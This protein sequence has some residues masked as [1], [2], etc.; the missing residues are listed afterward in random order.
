MLLLAVFAVMLGMNFYESTWMTAWAEEP[1]GISGAADGSNV[2]PD[3]PENGSGPPILSEASVRIGVL[4]GSGTEICRQMWQPTMDYLAQAISDR[5]FILVPLKFDEIEPAVRNRSV[6][7]LICNPAIYINLEVRYGMTRILSLHNRLGTRIVSE[8]GGVIFCRA[9]RTDLQNLRDVRGQRIAATDQTSFGGWVMALRE[10]RAEGMD[11]GH[12]CRQ[13]VFLDTH[14]AVV[15]AVLTDQADIGIVRTDTIERMAAGGEIRMDEIRVISARAASEGN[16]SFPYL[17]ST[18]LYPEWPI[19]K[20]SGVNDELAR[21]LTVALLVMPDSSP[22]AVAAHIGGWSVCRSYA[23]VHDCLREL[24]MPPYEHYGEI[25]LMDVWR[26]YRM[27]IMAIVV[28]ITALSGALMLLRGKQLAIM[29]VSSQNQLLL[30]SAGGGICGTDIHGMTTFVNPAAG[31]ILGYSADE[32]IGRSL[33]ALTH[34]TKPDGSPYPVHECPI[35]MAFKD[36]TVHEGSSEFFYRKD[37]SP[38]PISYSSRP[39]IDKGKITGAIVCFQDITGLKRAEESLLQINET[40]EQRVEQEVQKNMEQER[41]LIHQS[42]MAAMGEMIN[43]IAHQW[44]QPLQAINLLV[45]NIR[46]EFQWGSLNSDYLEQAVADSNRMVQKMSATISGF[47]TF[48]HSDK[49]VRR[50]FSAREQ[51]RKTVALVEESFRNSHI[52]VHID[53]PVDLMLLGFPYE[54]S[55]VLFHLLSNAGDAIQSHDKSYRGRVDVVLAEE[56]GRGCVTV[57]DTGG[58]IPEDIRGR[59]FDPYFSTKGMGNGIGLYM[60]KMIIERHMNGSITVQ[61]IEGGAEFRVSIPL[62]EDAPIDLDLKAG[63]K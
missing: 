41:M 30:E 54:Y 62:A 44:R 11:P 3:Q 49:N 38:I 5:S 60:S 39:V 42:R 15:R 13:V 26:Q 24:K 37:G 27:W 40:L 57:R 12:D 51:I 36:G 34:H 22:A 14:P 7:F 25:S 17:H 35:Y 29:K 21:R 8:F 61:N 9:N 48:F 47:S 23:H 55:Q 28:L 45:Y 6:D 2:S 56:E 18:R 31:K 43:N 58:G 4:A 63:K 46:D 19:A 10:F 20:L 32:L 53:D 50:A 33:H 59:I 16:S 1:A 52:S